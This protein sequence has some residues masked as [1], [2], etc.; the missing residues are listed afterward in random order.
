LDDVNSIVG[1]TLANV[2]KRV[3]IGQAQFA[4]IN[5]LA[6][7][8]RSVV[9]WRAVH[10]LGSYPHGDSIALGFELFD[11]D[12]VFW[13]RYGA[14]RAIVEMAA[15]ANAELRGRIVDGI[16]MRRDVL[17]EDT[18]L[19]DELVRALRIRRDFTSDN[20]VVSALRILA[21]FLEVSS[22]LENLEYWGRAIRGLR[23]EYMR[24]DVRQ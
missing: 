12:E 1:W 11:K 16:I 9:R 8:E 2:L 4:L 17:L 14:I 15:K 13:V 22:S 20:W 5:N 3:T 10:V 24:H 18:G 6:R 7:H 19:R 23:E 21:A